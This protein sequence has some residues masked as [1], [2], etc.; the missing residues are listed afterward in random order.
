MFEFNELNDFSQTVK[1]RE[2]KKHFKKQVSIKKDDL[3]DKK[4]P[5]WASDF[6]LLAKVTKLQQ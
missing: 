6:K 1:T 2:D 3:F 5:T 4:I